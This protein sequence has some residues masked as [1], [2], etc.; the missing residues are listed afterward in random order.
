MHLI[1]GLLT[2]RQIFLIPNIFA[3]TLENK[4]CF[5]DAAFKKVF[6]EKLEATGNNVRM[7]QTLARL[8]NIGA[9]DTGKNVL[10][11]E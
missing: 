11:C 4:M 8:A 6:T 10:L 9:T 3:K 2:Q 5:R 1:S 7:L